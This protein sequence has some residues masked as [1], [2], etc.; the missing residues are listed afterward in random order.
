[1]LVKKKVLLKIPAMV[2]TGTQLKSHVCCCRCPLALYQLNWLKKKQK[3]K[4]KQMVQS[5]NNRSNKPSNDVR[6]S[7]AYPNIIC[8]R[9]SIS[10]KFV[11]Q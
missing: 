7:F 11:L 2:D 10:K 1:M 5:E 4:K 8:L 3:K 6:T 9:L